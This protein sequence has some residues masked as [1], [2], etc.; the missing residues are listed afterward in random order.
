LIDAAIH[1]NL[2]TRRRMHLIYMQD[3]QIG[4]KI[5]WLAPA[6]M[7]RLPPSIITK[8]IFSNNIVCQLGLHLL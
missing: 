1:R 2:R 4:P 7:G 5:A 8:K 6:D 3:D